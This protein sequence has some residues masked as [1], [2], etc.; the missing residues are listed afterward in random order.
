[1]EK[2]E[3][4]HFHPRDDC[5][6]LKLKHTDTP[7][8]SLFLLAS[9]QHTHISRERHSVP[10]SYQ[11]FPHMS[12]TTHYRQSEFSLLSL[13]RASSVSHPLTQAAVV[14]PGHVCAISIY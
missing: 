13:S 4:F 14:V 9:R 10:I 5:D 6:W 11:H 12:S 7:L 8:F 2:H 3:L 1:M